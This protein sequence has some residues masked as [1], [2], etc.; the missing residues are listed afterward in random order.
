MEVDVMEAY[1]AEAEIEKL[2]LEFERGKD[3]LCTSWK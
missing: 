2:C 3:Y 1:E